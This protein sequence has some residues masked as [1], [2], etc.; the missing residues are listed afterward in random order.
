MQAGT[1]TDSAR[2]EDLDW[3][4]ACE[5]QNEAH[6]GMAAHDATHALAT[7]CGCI[8]L[9]CAQAVANAV[10]YDTMS[11][12]HLECSKCKTNPVYVSSVTRLKP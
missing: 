6:V 11:G 9:A 3:S 12:H 4:P 8:I 5:S 7:T 2:L 10:F 1:E